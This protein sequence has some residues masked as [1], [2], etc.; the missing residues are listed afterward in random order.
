[1]Q[2]LSPHICTQLGKQIKLVKKASLQFLMCV[3]YLGRGEG[4][5]K[6]QTKRQEDR[7][8]E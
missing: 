6:T 8:I 2:G 5:N 3:K 4:G 7:K 1:M